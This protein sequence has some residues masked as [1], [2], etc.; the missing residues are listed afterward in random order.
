MTNK[1]IKYGAGETVSHKTYGKGTI[2]SVEHVEK[3]SDGNHTMYVVEMIDGKTRNFKESELK[4]NNR[5]E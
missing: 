4:S 1:E 5:D 2:K 3:P